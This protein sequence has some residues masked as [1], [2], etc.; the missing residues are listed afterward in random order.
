[1]SGNLFSRKKPTNFFFSPSFD[2]IAARLFSSPA[3]LLL[4]CFNVF[5]FYEAKFNYRSA[6]L[7]HQSFCCFGLF[8][9]VKEIKNINFIAFAT[10]KKHAGTVSGGGNNN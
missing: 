2:K 1:M 8:F 10:T 9:S 6:S 7:S 3:R 5:A 4:C